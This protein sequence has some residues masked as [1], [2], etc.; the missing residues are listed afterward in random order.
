MLMR[1]FASTVLLAGFCASVNAQ[2]TWGGLRFGMTEGEA[3]AGLKTRVVKDIRNDPAQ[4]PAG[5]V[6][7]VY[8]AFKVTGVVLNDFKG[9]ASLLFSATTK[10]LEQVNVSLKTTAVE[11]AHE[12]LVT[13]LSQKY[14]KPVVEFTC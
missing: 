1:V 6:D 14:G 7:S 12:W 10:R 8:A 11:V 4:Q 2:A 5:E 3:K 13:E 9:S